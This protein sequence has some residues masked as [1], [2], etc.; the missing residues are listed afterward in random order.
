MEWEAQIRRK[1]GKGEKERKEKE[2]FGYRL[3]ERRGNKE[4]KQVFSRKIENRKR[5]SRTSDS[6][7]ETVPLG[8]SGWE[9]RHAGYSS[10]GIQLL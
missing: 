8:N 5:K 4:T 1:R 10:D 3:D 9:Y 2:K 6:K 7:V